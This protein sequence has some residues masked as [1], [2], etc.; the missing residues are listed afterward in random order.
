M[1]A[2]LIR[3]GVIEEHEAATHPQRH[4]ITRVLGMEGEVEVDLFELRL[5]E[6]DRVL[7][8]S[9]GLVNELAAEEIIRVLATQSDP[10][11]AAEDLVRRANAN[12]G[13]DN[14]S[15]VLIDALV[16]ESDPGPKVAPTERRVTTPSAPPTTEGW[17]ARRRR[18]GAPR[19]LTARTVAFV[20]LVVGVLI[21]GWFFLRWFAQSEYY[22]TTEG[23]HVVIYQGRPGGVLWFHPE[24]VETTQVTVDEVLPIRL[25]AL[26][27]KVVEPSLSAAQSYVRNLTSEAQQATP[28]TTTTAPG[29][30][31][32]P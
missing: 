31:G 30:P 28:T 20:V 7:L 19:V 27:A 10:K 3:D 26:K 1:V 16:A 6:G 2:Q 22:V 5:L 15:V 14:V 32:S 25:P 24:K 23:T 18:L 17:L 9:D 11:A 29:A 12:G 13:A 4:V 21:G 8:C